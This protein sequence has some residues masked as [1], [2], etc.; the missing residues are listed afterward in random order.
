[1]TTTNETS[2]E[3]HRQINDWLDEHTVYRDGSTP[4]IHTWTA[5]EK[6]LTLTDALTEARAEIER[7]SHFARGCVCTGG[8]ADDPDIE[9][10]YEICNQ[11]RSALAQSILKDAPKE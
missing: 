5:K 11:A 10:A 7:L 6:L 2:T 3:T 9:C 4:F 8:H 1:M